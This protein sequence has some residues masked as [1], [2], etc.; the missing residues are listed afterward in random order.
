MFSCC[1]PNADGEEVHVS[2]S[3]LQASQQEVLPPVPTR[4][5]EEKPQV[6]TPEVA[7]TEVA[8]PAAAVAPL[9]EK[10]EEV[11]TVAP[12][13][14]QAEATAAIPQVYIKEFDVKLEKVDGMGIGL[15]LVSR[16]L[17]VK[18]IINPGMIH[19]YNETVGEA[20]LKVQPGHTLLSFNGVDGDPLAI[21]NT[22]KA[23]VPTMKAGAAITLRF[24]VV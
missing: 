11:V 8:P 21:L 22:L 10:R 5:V 6:S 17:K 20:G 15:E 12:P 2:V 7:T 16:T 4:K 14:T 23:N 24:R 18:E 19:S 9:K 13:A 1:A 3:A